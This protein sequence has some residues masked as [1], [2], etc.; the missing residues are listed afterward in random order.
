MYKRAQL[1]LDVPQLPPRVPVPQLPPRVPV[2]PPAAHT[3]PPAK[4]LNAFQQQEQARW[5]SMVAGALRYGGLG[6]VVGGAGL[7]INRWLSSPDGEDPKARRTATLRQALLGAA[8]GGAIGTGAPI[9][10]YFTHTPPT[11][12]RAIV[13]KAL[14]AAHHKPFTVATPL[15][16]LMQRFARKGVPGIVGEPLSTRIDRAVKDGPPLDDATT[17]AYARIRDRIATIK[18]DP[19]SLVYSPALPS[20]VEALKAQMARTPPPSTEA[21]GT[22]LMMRPP[23]MPPPRSA[24]DIAAEAPWLLKMQYKHVEPS[25]YKR[26]M[27][28]GGGTAL[29]ALGWG[30]AGNFADHMLQLSYP[31]SA[32]D[33]AAK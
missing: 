6:A 5:N 25:A 7:G 32:A 3:P 2:P 21:P 30:A 22:A 4:P 16:Y 19:Q 24:L 33:P 10:G 8:M 28:G 26:V 17:A 29:K 9:A 14:Q 13:D 27:S 11:A 15:A 12:L 18:Q 1:P 23:D 20:T 31:Q